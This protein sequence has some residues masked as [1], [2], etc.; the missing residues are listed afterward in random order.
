MGTLNGQ[1]LGLTLT[2]GTILIEL[3]L[4]IYMQK[5]LFP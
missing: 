5:K 4:Y 2:L 1:Q 3:V